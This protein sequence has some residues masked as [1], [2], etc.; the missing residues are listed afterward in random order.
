MAPRK[1]QAGKK[2]TSVFIFINHK[3][4]FQV[5]NKINS[6]FVNSRSSFWRDDKFLYA[7][8]HKTGIKNI[9]TKANIPPIKGISLI[10]LIHFISEFTFV[11]VTMV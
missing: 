5:G 10:D 9:N 11:I 1:I 3:I 8:E 2:K 6:A 4:K 7:K